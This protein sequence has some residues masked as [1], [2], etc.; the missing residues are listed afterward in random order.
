[1]TKKEDKEKKKDDERF[2]FQEYM[3]TVELNKYLKIG[4]IKSLKKEPKTLTETR[5]LLKKYLGE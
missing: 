1:M 4:F 2:N 3:E 5:K